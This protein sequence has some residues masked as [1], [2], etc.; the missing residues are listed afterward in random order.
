MPRYQEFRK[1]VPAVVLTGCVILSGC[2]IRQDDGERAYKSLPDACGLVDARLVTRLIGNGMAAKPST[3]PRTNEVKQSACSFQNTRQV[4]G[5][6]ILIFANIRNG[7]DAIRAT[8]ESFAT[9]HSECGKPASSC[10]QVD[11]GDESYIKYSQVGRQS[12]D[13][14]FREKNI[15]A[16]VLYFGPLL[17]SGRKPI[18]VNSFENDGLAVARSILGNLHLQAK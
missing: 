15:V 7:D 17:S 5:S 13:I 11:V 10:R 14:S 12:A 18:P 2:F 9:D 16:A 4:T 8:R 3:P 6:S 1:I